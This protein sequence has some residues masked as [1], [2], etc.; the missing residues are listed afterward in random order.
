LKHI[1]FRKLDSFPSSGEGEGILLGWA[2]QNE[3]DAITEQRQMFYSAHGLYSVAVK[4]HQREIRIEK[5]K[6][7]PE[8]LCT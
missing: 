1:T 2:R 8:T 7:D 3:L 6:K 5:G 4:Y